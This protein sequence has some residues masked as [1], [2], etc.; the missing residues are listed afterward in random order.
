MNVPIFLAAVS[1]KSSQMEL[2][3]IW[4]Q[5]T[6]EAKVI[7]F[8]LFIFSVIAWFVM[9]SKALQMRRAKKLNLFFTSEFR[10]KKHVLDMF[11]PA[12]CRRTAARCSWF[13]RPAAWNWT[14]G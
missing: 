8:C 4:D 9:I 11:R 5:A 14:R 2:V 13:I 12:S 3:Y 7:I 6:P 10:A 1:D